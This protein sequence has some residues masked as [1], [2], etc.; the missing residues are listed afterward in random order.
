MLLLDSMAWT[1]VFFTVFIPVWLIQMMDV[2]AFLIRSV[3]S[4]LAWMVVFVFA[5][6]ANALHVFLCTTSV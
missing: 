6:R 3:F 1:M 5:A 4:L 2:I